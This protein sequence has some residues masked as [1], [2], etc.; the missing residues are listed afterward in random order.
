MLIHLMK[1]PLRLYS[2][3]RFDVSHLISTGHTLL[4]GSVVD[5]ENFKRP[6]YI[7]TVLL[8]NI[9]GQDGR[10]ELAFLP[11]FHHNTTSLSGLEDT[12]GRTTNEFKGSKPHA[13]GEAIDKGSF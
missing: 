8:G 4:P 9:Q 6:G 7:E 12:V 13:N 5:L 10:R 11:A 2:C 1:Q 3:I